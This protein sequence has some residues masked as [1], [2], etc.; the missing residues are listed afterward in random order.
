LFLS[1][2]PEK[3]LPVSEERKQVLPVVIPG[4]LVLLPETRNLR[5]LK[6]SETRQNA[7]SRRLF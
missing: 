1:H 2:D 7:T 3:F 5:D 6:V 4:I